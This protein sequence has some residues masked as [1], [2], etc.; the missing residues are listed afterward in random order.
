MQ[1][2]LNSQS[3]RQFWHRSL[4]LTFPSIWGEAQ[5][6]GW[7]RG[8]LST[9]SAEGS[10]NPVAY[11][12]NTRITTFVPALTGWR[13][14]FT[15]SGA[16]QQN[17][18]SSVVPRPSCTCALECPSTLPDY[19]FVVLELTVTLMICLWDGPNLFASGLVSGWLE[20]FRARE[21]QLRP[22]PG[23]FPSMRRCH[24]PRVVVALEHVGVALRAGGYGASPRPLYS[25]PM[26]IARTRWVDDH[27]YETHKPPNRPPH[28]VAHAS[29]LSAAGNWA[30]DWACQ[31]ARGE[32]SAL[33]G[34]LSPIEPQ[35][36][37]SPPPRHRLAFSLI[38]KIANGN[39]AADG[40]T[41]PCMSMNH[42]RYGI[43]CEPCRGLR[44]REP[45]SGSCHEGRD[46]PSARIHMVVEKPFLYALRDKVTGLILVAG[47]RAG[48]VG[49]DG[50]TE[51]WRFDPRPSA[52]AALVCTDCDDRRRD[53]HR[54]SGLIVCEFIVAYLPVATLPMG[55]VGPR[56]VLA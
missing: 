23:S 45:G 7:S 11:E 30:S 38:E 15:G 27:G 44:R 31:T 12:P 49:E 8:I 20:K 47:S 41:L 13:T 42:R 43:A 26:P 50:G 6:S 25:H 2:S 37:G 48:A 29:W 36:T 4:T 54:Q 28:Q 46:R 56:G 5:F 52:K 1:Q 40:C 21:L 51:Y 53:H 24:Q 18:T 14:P 16:A 32:L 22:P 35:L 55:T 3:R 34:V 19:P 10:G 17:R 9:P 33:Q 39:N